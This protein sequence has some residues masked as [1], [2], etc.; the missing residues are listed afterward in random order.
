MQLKE[1]ITNYYN[2]Y[3]IIKDIITCSY[4]FFILS[5]KKFPA[6]SARAL[7]QSSQIFFKCWNYVHAQ[8]LFWYEVLIQSYDQQLNISS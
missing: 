1:I 6:H 3:L 8:H 2:L 4:M 5:K 7:L